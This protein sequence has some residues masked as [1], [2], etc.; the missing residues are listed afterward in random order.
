MKTKTS[1]AR[2]TCPK[3]VAGRLRTACA[4][5]L[6]A[7]LLLLTLPAVVQAQFNYTTNNGT[8]TITGYTGPGGVVTIP[9]TINGLPVTTI[10]YFAFNYCT[11][12]TSVTIPNTVTSI[13]DEAFYLCY[14]L[15]NVTIP[16]SVTSIGYSSFAACGLTSVTIPSSVTNI[17]DCAFCQCS[18]LLAIT[19]DT[20]NPAYHSVAGVLFNKSQ[21]MLIQYTLGKG[22]GSYTVPNSVTNI[23]ILAFCPCYSLTNITI[24]N[25]VTSIG[26]EAFWGCSSLNG[27]TIPAS[28]TK[29]GDYAFAWCNRMT[30]ITVEAANSFYI[31]VGGV[32]FN[33]SHTTLIEYPGG[34]KAGSYTI[35]ASVTNI[36]GNA[37]AGCY[38]LTNI[39]I[40]N[41]VTSIGYGAFYSC[42]GLTSVTIP[43]SVAKIGDYAFAWCTGLSTITV[44]ASNTVYSSVDGS[45]FNKSHTT[46]IEYPGGSKAGSYTI[47]ASVTNIE[48]NAFAGCYSLTNITIGNSVT[49]IGYE[50]FVA[51]SS[52]ASITIPS[53]VSSIGSWA[54]S[55]CTSLIGVYFHG[56]APSLGSDVFDYDN[57]ATVYYMPRTT[58][59]GTTFGGRPTA[60]WT[61]AL[62]VSP[63]KTTA[64]GSVMVGTTRD[65]PFKVSNVGAS[66]ISGTASVASPFSVVS[67]GSYTLAPGHSTNTTIRYAPTSAGNNTA[68]VTFTGG[69]GATVTVT[70]SAPA[71]PTPTSGTIIGRV[72]RS[73]DQTAL[74]NVSITAVGP[75]SWFDNSAG[76]VSG[77]I[78]GQAGSFSISGLAPFAHYHVLASAPGQQFEFAELTNV[79]V[80]AGQT[81]TV[82]IQ[83]TPVPPPSQPPTLTPEQTPV[84]LVR[85]TGSDKDWSAGESGYW[86]AIRS[87]LIGQGFQQVWDCNQP[88]NDPDFPIYSG[89]GHVINGEREIW[90]NAVALDYFIR[91]K[92]EQF[93]RDKGYYPPTINIVAHSMGGLITRSAMID[94]SFSLVSSNGK[95]VRIKVNKVVMLATPNAGTAI[96][97]IGIDTGLN[98]D[99]YYALTGWQ[100]AWPATKDLTTYYIQE[101]FNG[102]YPW[103]AGVK[104]YLLGGGGGL[105]SSSFTLRTG[106]R[107]L[108]GIPG[109]LPPVNLFLPPEQVNDG[110]VTWP[111]VQGKF[112]KRSLPFM[113]LQQFTSVS[114]TPSGSPSFFA[115]LDHFEILDAPDV[116][117]WVIGDLKGTLLS[118][119]I[120][121]NNA[122]VNEPDGS[123]KAGT[124]S[125]PMQQIEQFS[126]TLSPG[127]TNEIAVISDADTTLEF[128]LLA[129]ATNIV[130]RLKNPAGTIIDFNTPGSNTNVQYS[131]FVGV[132]NTLMVNYKINN[133]IAGIWKVIV[134]GASLTTTQAM[135]NLMA[136]GDS[137]VALIPQTDPL[138]S[139]GQDVMVSCAL[140]D[141]STNPAMPM[142]NASITATIKLPDGS[143]TNLTV[144]DDGWHN[145]GAANDGVYGAMLANVQQAG[146]YS[147]AYRATGTN[148]QGQALQRVATGTFSVSSGH[149]SLWGDPVYEYLDTDGDGIAD[150][151]EVKC[152]VNPTAA[153]N[154]ILAGDLV[155]ASGTHRFSKSAAFA[156]DGSG[157]ATVT[158][159]FDLA[160]MLTAGAR[161]TL[162]IEDL[163]LFEV[164]STGTAWLDAY[165]GS[166]VV[167]IQPAKAINVSPLNLATNVARTVDLQWTDGGG[168]SNYDVYFGTNA[169]SLPLMTN[170]TGT[171]YDPGTLAYNKT[172]YWRIDVKNAFGTEQ[173]DTWSFTTLALY[174]TCTTNNGTITITGYT[175]PGGAVTIPDTINDLPVT[176]IGN[177]AFYNCTN[178]TSVTI[179]DSVT[180]IGGWAFAFC[181]S[182]TSVTIGNSVTNIG[183]YTFAFC[184]NLTGIIIPDSV[185]NIGD[186]AFFSC[187]SLTSATIGNSVTS[188]GDYA[189][190][191]CTGLTG[192]YFHGNAPSA[193]SSV[194]YSDNNATVYFLWGKTGWG[195]TFGG[196]PTVLWN[197]EAQFNYT[198]N[199]GTITITGYNGPGGAVTI[200]DTINDLPVTSIGDGAFSWCPN[201]T[202]VII[203]NSV[204]NI[205]DWAFSGCDSLTN[206]TI[207]NNVTSIGYDAFYYCTS[208]ISVMIPDSVTNIGDNAF[209][210]CTGL[211][212]ITVN[213]SN[214]V[215]SSV[216][217]SLFNKNQTTLI[218]YPA[219][220]AES[221][222]TVPDSVTTI[223]FAAFAGCS[224]LTSVTIPVSVTNIGDDAFNYC[225]GLTN[226][227]IPNS[228]TNIGDRAFSGC[229]SLTN[230]TIGNSV[231]SIGDGTFDSCS[232][233]TSVTIPDS[234][235]NIGDYALYSCTSLTTSR[236]PTASPASGTMRSLA[237]TT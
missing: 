165:Q 186:G 191:S 128:D 197:P 194:F 120:P 11:N 236:F 63:S 202:D 94:G 122:P 141:L 211:S 81:T 23:G 57:N 87:A 162:H 187:T 53:S 155:D 231:T 223:G 28:V 76:T 65:L 26:V 97:D 221:I 72:M 210:W 25:N 7:L 237:A 170:Q 192:V 16:N 47:P 174:Y 119:A 199:N 10:G 123:S 91:Q 66:A 18:G 219:G 179:P 172:Y 143:S 69:N 35:P 80:Q 158:L 216:D 137:S 126:S 157:P 180:N 156:A 215:Y 52:L 205:G 167:D 160:E 29:I 148:A 90:L 217:G 185:T 13:R 176:S 75:G 110:A 228:V 37:F 50:A 70:G 41:S 218:Q 40:G 181:T 183:D 139:Q 166:S 48:G 61:P 227:T 42:I 178:L 105:G 2:T 100:L 36:E 115:D 8:I 203:G 171:T 82:N 5:R 77:V 33:K 54:F 146:T 79:N 188:I 51:C 161:G 117:T 224:S 1:I 163:Q 58:G 3:T 208:L 71:D 147:I 62:I 134:D 169:A 27:V 214:T 159:I 151:L 104:L 220:K 83:L 34:S 235:T 14:G 85:G 109:A 232:S 92:A 19:V 144:F 86:S 78:A 68:N 153:G 209:A 107:A 207:G 32:L 168:A 164:T 60:L 125:L 64:Y 234:V 31:S 222:Y 154:Y 233:L 226:I 150:F 93:N 133:P 152:W 49:S 190:Y 24:G 116:A 145:D 43:A 96:A 177:F 200:P 213:A 59:W 114:L 84:V 6:L 130:L 9:S 15:T 106:G 212:T 112:Y 108:A 193:D 99:F 4:T 136:F 132:S 198:I 102:S 142:V 22:D 67:G 206:I 129:S 121:R 39:I 21:T 138:F 196:R 88:D 118:S 17:G 175:G 55:S 103:P 95:W 38:S 12:L 135:Y 113:E 131:A 140:A 182:L 111:S 124:N 201:L 30:A 127:R 46:L 229:Y 189:F 204:T 20:N 101:T 195:T 73:D 184:I 173:G 74:N 56:N 230:I 149:G 98:S 225:T 45:L 44:N 89:Q